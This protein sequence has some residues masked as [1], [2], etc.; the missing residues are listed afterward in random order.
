MLDYNTE[1][2]LPTVRR[3]APIPTLFTIQDQVISQFLSCIAVV[4]YFRLSRTRHLG[5][6]LIILADCTRQ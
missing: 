1:D 4:F 6:E 3:A 5:I 2:E